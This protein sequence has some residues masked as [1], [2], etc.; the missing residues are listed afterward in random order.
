MSSS[1]RALVLLTA[2]LHAR[3]YVS[4]I[5][6][7]DDFNPNLG[8]AKELL[9]Y[10]CEYGH[11]ELISFLIHQGTDIYTHD[12]DGTCVRCPTCS[13]VWLQTASGRNPGWAENSCLREGA[14]ARL[15]L[16]ALT[17]A[18]SLCWAMDVGYVALG[19]CLEQGPAPGMCRGLDSM[20]VCVGY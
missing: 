13:V 5:A 2:K 17:G 16:S 11:T 19:A 18:P 9:H 7:G 10:A 4:Q 1:V 3:R 8:E 20:R 14:G 12:P 15:L 6:S